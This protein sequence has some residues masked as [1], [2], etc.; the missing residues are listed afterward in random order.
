[1]KKFLK[2]EEKGYLIM[3]KGIIKFVLQKCLGFK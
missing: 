1:M 2:K 3:V